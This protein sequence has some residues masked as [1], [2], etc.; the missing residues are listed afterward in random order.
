MV[1]EAISNIRESVSFDIQTPWS[2]L[3]KTWLRLVFSTTSRC[4]DVGWNT[5]PRVWYITSQVS[6]NFLRRRKLGLGVDYGSLQQIRNISLPEWAFI[7]IHND[8]ITFIASY[9][10]YTTLP[11]SLSSYTKIFRTLRYHQAQA[12][13]PV[14]HQ[15]SQ[16]N[17]LNIAQYRKAVHSALWVKL[18]LVVCFAPFFIVVTVIAHS[19]THSSHLVILRGITVVLVTLTRR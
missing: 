5:L 13:N 2:W 14:Q 17:V 4:L 3:K 7:N 11:D 10:N 9:H 12:E 1:W 8:R 18:A 6:W 19:K 16:L 15:P